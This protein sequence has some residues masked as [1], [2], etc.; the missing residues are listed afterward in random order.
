M[1]Q[2]DKARVKK[3]ASAQAGSPSDVR[4]L[5]KERARRRAR[6]SKRQANRQR[7]ILG[8]GVLVAL[9][10]VLWVL[11]G[12][13]SLSA[14][15]AGVG[16]GLSLVY[17]AGFGYIM[18]AMAQATATDEEAIAKIDRKLKSS[19]GA[20][21][22]ARSRRPVAPK[23]GNRPSSGRPEADR[24]GRARGAG[25]A[26]ASSS[27]S[28]LAQHEEA[29]NSSEQRANNKAADDRA[30]V[31][32][33]AEESVKKLLGE[34]PGMEAGSKVNANWP[35][36]SQSTVTEG[37]SEEETQEKAQTVR[38]ESA[39]SGAAAGDT[40]AG[41][42]AAGGGSGL[43]MSLEPEIVEDSA[44]IDVIS[45]EKRE[46]REVAAA[47]SATT[48]DGGPGSSPAPSG[49]EPEAVSQDATQSADTSVPSYTAKPRQ[50]ERRVVTPYEAPQE[51]E[52]AVP[53]RPKEVGERFEEDPETSKPQSGSDG[54]SGGSA[55][56]A[57]LDRR[58]A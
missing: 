58:R 11:V 47:Y 37:H 3:A 54:L 24:S 12:V 50:V 13:T 2:N 39:A 20:A 22:L 49:A 57:L 46:S 5:A 33:R 30:Q 25:A 26:A 55:L 23:T 34:Q 42:A 32:R 28:S 8:A 44:D 31:E 56:D 14:V 19:K 9:C 40:T 17:L 41:D 48:T 7:G 45:D 27:E 43:A 18:N 53:Y 35:K 52:A 15:V 6:I 29:R 36:T 51:P 4:A 1:S 16:T 10:V 21:H 38:S